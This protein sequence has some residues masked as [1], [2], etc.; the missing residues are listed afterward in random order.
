MLREGEEFWERLHWPEVRET[1]TAVFE[2][3]RPDFSRF[4]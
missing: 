3:R 4:D 1:F 2:R